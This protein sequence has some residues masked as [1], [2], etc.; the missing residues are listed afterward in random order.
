MEKGVKMNNRRNFFAVLFGG[1]LGLISFPFRAFA[2][3]SPWREIGTVATDSGSLMVCDP[4]Y[5]VGHGNKEKPHYSE[6]DKSWSEFCERDSRGQLL[7]D[8]GTPGLGVIVGSGSG[9]VVE[10]KEGEGRILEVRIRFP[11]P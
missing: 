11:R 1:L 6:F 4:C 10:V 3:S 8:H 7:F 5:I 9:G 2:S